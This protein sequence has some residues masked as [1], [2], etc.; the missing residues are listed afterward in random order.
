MPKLS[1]STVNYFTKLFEQHAAK[2]IEFYCK[3][4]ERELSRY[5]VIRIDKKIS[6]LLL[7]AN[8]KHVSSK[9]VVN[10]ASSERKG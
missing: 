10:R 1:S 5:L 8:S 4:R 9:G 7:V 6:V 2:R 3:K